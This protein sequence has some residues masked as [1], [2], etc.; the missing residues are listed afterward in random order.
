MNE[1]DTLISCQ[2]FLTI[3]DDELIVVVIIHTL[4]TS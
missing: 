4:G 3:E 1:T 2:K